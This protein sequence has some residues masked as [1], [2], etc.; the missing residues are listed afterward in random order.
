MKVLPKKRG[1]VFN[2]AGSVGARVADAEVVI[3]RT[4]VRIKGL[5]VE[6]GDGLLL[7]RIVDD[8]E[9]PVLTVR[10]GRR[11]E[12]QIDTLTDEFSRYRSVEVEAFAHRPG[13]GEE[14]VRRKCEGHDG[15][16][17]REVTARPSSRSP[18]TPT[19]PLRSVGWRT[20]ENRKAPLVTE[21]SGAFR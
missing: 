11:L 10:A 8:H 3:A 6:V 17:Y 12:R 16:N 19:T 4:D 21:S 13:G 2:G 7:G 18:T 15:Q 20:P 14:F 1:R 9:A 5:A